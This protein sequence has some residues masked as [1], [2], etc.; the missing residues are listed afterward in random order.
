MSLPCV[1]FPLPKFCSLYYGRLYG[2]WL[3]LGLVA[4]KFVMLKSHRPPPGSQF[5]R[6]TALLPLSSTVGHW[7]FV[8]SSLELQT[9]DFG[10]LPLSSAS[11]VC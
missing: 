7:S 1:M 9:L 3:L 11:D 10:S 8:I 4:M 5:I 2:R 6:Q